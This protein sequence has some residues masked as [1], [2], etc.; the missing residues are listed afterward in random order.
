MPPLTPDPEWY[1]VAPALF[2]DD[3]TGP[4]AALEA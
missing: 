3:E 2:A 4:A 1:T